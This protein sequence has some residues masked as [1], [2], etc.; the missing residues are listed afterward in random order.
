MENRT[1]LLKCNSGHLTALLK[2]LQQLF[3]LDE[4]KFKLLNV[5]YKPFIT[6]SKLTSLTSSPFILFYLW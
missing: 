1:F 6:W 2:T 4:I 3:L 5:A